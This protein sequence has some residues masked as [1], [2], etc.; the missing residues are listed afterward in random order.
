MVTRSCNLGQKGSGADV[1]PKGR[2]RIVGMIS[3]IDYKAKEMV[4]L[5]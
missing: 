5:Q 1:G 2:I 4:G 3:G